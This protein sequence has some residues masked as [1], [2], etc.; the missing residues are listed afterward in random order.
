MGRRLLSKLYQTK[1]VLISSTHIYYYQSATVIVYSFTEWNTALAVLKDSVEHRSVSKTQ[2]LYRT[3]T[4][5]CS[6]G[7]SLTT[8]CLYPAHPSEEEHEL[9]RHKKL[10]VQWNRQRQSAFLKRGTSL[11]NPSSYGF[12]TTCSPLSKN[13]EMSFR[14]T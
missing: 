14:E 2:K 13:Q 7:H 10:T 4:S 5:A 3:C 1:H 12:N 11:N 8:E 9:H 6:C